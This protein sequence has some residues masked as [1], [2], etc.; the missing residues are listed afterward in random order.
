MFRFEYK[1]KLPDKKGSI[2]FVIITPITI[3]HRL[4]NNFVV[5]PLQ[6]SLK[7]LYFL[8]EYFN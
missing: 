5:F 7:A 3:T 4:K 1:P 2:I 8:F 6:Y